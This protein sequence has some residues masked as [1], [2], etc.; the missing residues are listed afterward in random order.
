[1]LG[2][3]VCTIILNA[4]AVSQRRKGGREEFPLL[5][6][7]CSHSLWRW[8]TFSSS[9]W[10][11]QRTCDFLWKFTLR[12]FKKTKKTICV[13][14]NL[15]SLKSNLSLASVFSR[16]FYEHISCQVSDVIR[17]EI[18]LCWSVG[19]IGKPIVPTPTQFVTQQ[20]SRI[21][22]TNQIT[23]NLQKLSLTYKFDY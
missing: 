2:H 4:Q 5:C 9:D 6:G 15:Q 8:S 10:S 7:F 14:I 3:R 13:T 17:D 20:R 23:R 19:V 16:K 11:Y 21:R 1:M 22:G 18:S 12:F